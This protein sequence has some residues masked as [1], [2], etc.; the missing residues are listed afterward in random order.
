MKLLPH[1]LILIGLLVLGFAAI[2]A[3]SRGQATAPLEEWG[4]NSSLTADPVKTIN[5]EPLTNLPPPPNREP[6]LH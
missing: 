3:T 4:L 6:C 1:R 2:I 5:E